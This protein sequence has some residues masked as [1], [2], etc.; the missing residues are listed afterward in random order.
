MRSKVVGLKKLRQE[1]RVEP[2][3]EEEMLLERELAASRPRYRADCIDGPR[4][5]VYLS[6]RHHLYL[7]VNDAGGIKLNF[8]DLELD[9]I[10]ETCALDVADHGGRT[11]DE[12]G[13]LMNVVRERVRQIE[14]QALKQIDPKEITG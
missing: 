7:E 13:A 10:K 9:E 6:C 14:Q 11:L 12:V 4:P 8:P 1:A 3:D 2:L 5:C